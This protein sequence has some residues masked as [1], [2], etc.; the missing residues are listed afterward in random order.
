L[1]VVIGIVIVI[2]VE[3]TDKHLE[4]V[5]KV[6]IIMRANVKVKDGTHYSRLIFREKEGLHHARTPI[7]RLQSR[8]KL[9]RKIRFRH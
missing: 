4:E 7:D 8:Q 6:H 1:E 3:R 5:S 2:R 9:G